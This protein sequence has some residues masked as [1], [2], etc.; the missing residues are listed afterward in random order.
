MWVYFLNCLG[1]YRIRVVLSASLGTHSW[2][3]FA[4]HHLKAM[5][6]HL[7]YLPLT[8][9]HG[10]VLNRVHFF[11]FF[12]SWAYVLCLIT[13]WFHILALVPSL[14]PSFPYDL[15]LGLIVSLKFD[16]SSSLMLSSTY[17]G[18]SLTLLDSPLQLTYSNYDSG[19]DECLQGEINF[20][21]LF[22]LEEDYFK[23][24][25]RKLLFLTETWPP[26]KKR[27]GKW[28]QSKCIEC[29]VTKVLSYT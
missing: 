1:Y 4:M 20:Y 16:F 11:F 24:A 29:N 17:W 5:Q 2:L 9:D 25:V 28:T 21:F 10:H 27:L 7:S 26:K 23:Y 13:E 6:I 22:F 12:L 19:K 3:W 15:C 18:L 8:S 14:S